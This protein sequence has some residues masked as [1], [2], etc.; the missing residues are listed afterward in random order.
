MQRSPESPIAPVPVR[1]L[2][3]ARPGVVVTVRSDRVDAVMNH[4]GRWGLT[5]GR[6]IFKYA[7]LSMQFEL[8][9]SESLKRVEVTAAI[10]AQLQALDVCHSTREPS[11]AEALRGAG[12]RHFVSVKWNGDQRA[13]HFLPQS[14]N[15]LR[16]HSGNVH[17]NN[18]WVTNIPNSDGGWSAVLL[19]Y[20][21][22]EKFSLDPTHSVSRSS[23]RPTRTPQRARRRWHHKEPLEVSVVVVDA[24]KS[25]HTKPVVQS[26][27]MRPNKS[28]RRKKS[29][30]RRGNER[31]ERQQ[32]EKKECAV[33]TAP[34]ERKERQQGE[35]KECAVTTAP[36]VKK[37]SVAMGADDAE[38]DGGA[39]EASTSMEI[40]V[41]D[42]PPPNRAQVQAGTAQGAMNADEAEGDRGATSGV[43]SSGIVQVR[44]AMEVDEPGYGEASE[45]EQ[46][47]E[48]VR[49]AHVVGEAED[50]T[51]KE[52]G[53]MEEKL[54]EPIARN[55][56]E[57][58]ARAD[59]ALR[60]TLESG[61]ASGAL[62][63]MEP[64]STGTGMGVS[65][66]E[67]AKR[68]RAAAE[69]EEA[70]QTVMLFEGVQRC[71]K[72]TKQE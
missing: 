51:G 6:S 56:D 69:R 11:Y 39:T 38:H 57:S 58:E 20:K 59:P 13:L 30:K 21:Q 60:V 63:R 1:V 10:K 14:A 32:G 25:R 65:T 18:I 41:D 46:K 43:P 8:F 71:A 7:D 17:D 26:M 15:E 53:E 55:E 19:R 68:A 9:H 27:E 24:G 64:A 34:P 36:P 4:I 44:D 62:A 48:N 49:A 50:V 70:N 66:R 37:K 2:A 28:G 12:Q 3:D 52:E 42:K 40:P 47:A 35:K 61:R 16:H 72:T 23:S 29:V 33:T 54:G 45:R 22:E 5:I 31:K 67:M